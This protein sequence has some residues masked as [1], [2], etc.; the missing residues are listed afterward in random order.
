MVRSLVADCPAAHLGA[1][2]D[3]GSDVLGTAGVAKRVSGL[4]LWL[5]PRRALYFPRLAATGRMALYG[6][7]VQFSLRWLNR[8]RFGPF[9]WL[10]RSLAYGKR[11]AMHKRDQEDGI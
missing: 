9:E 2:E 4:L 3:G 11:Q 10:W 1:F 8:F 6:I 5:T 7:Q